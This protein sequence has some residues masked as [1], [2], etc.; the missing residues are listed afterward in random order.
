M[1]EQSGD[2]P[3]LENSLSLGRGADTHVRTGRLAESISLSGKPTVFVTQFADPS[4]FGWN[5][6][7]R[8]ACQVHR[9]KKSESNGLEDVLI[10]ENI[11]NL[12][13]C[14]PQPSD[15]ESKKSFAQGEHFPY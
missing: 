13:S 12:K 1:G 7:Q 5:V 10:V 2:Q 4:T 9:V 6:T 8:V 3:V 11:A 14:S 15:L